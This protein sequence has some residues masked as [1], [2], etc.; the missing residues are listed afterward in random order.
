MDK[1]I[2]QKRQLAVGCFH[3]GRVLKLH[4]YPWRKAAAETENAEIVQIIPLDLVE[5]AGSS[6]EKPRK[7]GAQSPFCRLQSTRPTLI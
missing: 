4:K 1:V 6:F 3:T 7:R 5:P 2:R